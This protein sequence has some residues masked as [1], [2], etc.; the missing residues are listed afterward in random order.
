[1][2]AVIEA[3]LQLRK[4]LPGILTRLIPFREAFRHTWEI[5]QATVVNKY[6]KK[7]NLHKER[8]VNLNIISR[9]LVCTAVRIEKQC[10]KE[11]QTLSRS[12]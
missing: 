11:N 2:A 12:Q 1:M 7:P 10:G 9:H 3:R 8:K 6:S 5:S 4:T